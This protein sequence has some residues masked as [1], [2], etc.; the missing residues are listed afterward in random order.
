MRIYKLCFVIFLAIGTCETYAQD[1]S[2]TLIP[3]SLRTNAH[4]V[5]R[6]YN[7][8]T[9]L[10]SLNSGVQRISRAI[11]I[12]DKEGESIAYLAIPYDKNTTVSIKQVVLFDSNGKKIKTVKQSDITDSPEFNSSELFSESRIKYY[13]PLNPV[14]PYTVLYEYEL[15][16]KNIISLGCWM[17]LSTYN[18][19]VQQSK[20]TF[21]HPSKVKI[22]KKEIKIQTKTSEV[23]ND[24]IVET[25]E[26]N[27][28]VA[29]ESEPYSISLSERVPCLYLMPSRLVYDK[30]EGTADTWKDY[31][32]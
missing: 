15:D 14:Y 4:C 24:I 20:L 8:E 3:D 6:A 29:V 25:W 13:K 19:S 18:L 31:G 23:H 1:Y 27:N 7:E 17:P 21:S 16:M 11:T 26:L 10:K 2:A 32:Q 5:I 30:Y 9:E 22:N 12:L 28:L